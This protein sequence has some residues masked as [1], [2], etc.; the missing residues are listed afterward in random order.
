MRRAAQ[1]LGMTPAAVSQQ[2]RHLETQLDTRLLHRSTRKLSLTEAGQA[3]FHHCQQMVQSAQEAEQALAAVRYQLAG[4][5]RMTAPVGLAAR[6]LPMALAPLLA[7]HP[8]L[9]LTLLASDE[10]LNMVENRLDIAFRAGPLEDSTLVATPVCEFPSR[11]CASPSYLE[12]HGTP[13]TPE[14]L[15]QHAFLVQSQTHRDGRLQLVH[16]TLGQR[17]VR[18][19]PKIQ[20]NNLQV[21]HR[22]ACQGLGLAVLPDHEAS[23]ALERGE[24]L[25]VLP[26]WQLSGLP[27]FMVT[28]DRHRTEKVEAVIA[29]VKRY[30]LASTGA[31]EPE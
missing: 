16:S 12:S 23:N 19:T 2:I 30:F 4:E 13:E 22:F 3:Y 15:E 21:V 7:Q 1:S 17:R 29:A 5:V 11:L 6:Q 10:C 26:G 14:A 18:I 31:R 25:P 24:L 28:P 8:K 27:F 9:T 20:T